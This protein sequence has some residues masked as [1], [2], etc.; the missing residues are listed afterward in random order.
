MNQ[1]P[2]HSDHFEHFW[3]FSHSLE[4][5]DPSV[6]YHLVVTSHPPYSEASSQPAAKQASV[7]VCLHVF[8]QVKRL[9]NQIWLTE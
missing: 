3:I 1:S 6:R 5:Q 8:A 7:C 9:Y 2:Y 4:L